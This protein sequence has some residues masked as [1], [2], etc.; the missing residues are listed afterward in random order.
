MKSIMG[1]LLTIILYIPRKI[2][3]GIRAIVLLIIATPRLIWEAPAKMYKRSIV[4]R[5]WLIAK[6]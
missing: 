4:W 3:R 5:D 6:V 2:Y 1:L